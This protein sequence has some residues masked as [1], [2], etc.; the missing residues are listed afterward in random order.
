M[1]CKCGKNGPRDRFHFV[2]ENTI[3]RIFMSFSVAAMA[4]SALYTVVGLIYYE[5]LDWIRQSVK[6]TV[7]LNFEIVAQAGALNSQDTFSASINQL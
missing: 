2:L 5:Q 1:C 7:L 4:I 3:F 6:P